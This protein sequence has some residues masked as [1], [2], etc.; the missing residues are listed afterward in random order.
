MRSVSRVSAS[1]SVLS[2][3]TFTIIA[4]VENNTDP[5]KVIA[6]PAQVMLYFGVS[7]KIFLHAHIEISQRII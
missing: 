7:G 5:M 4:F 6:N 3:A 1:I 2:N